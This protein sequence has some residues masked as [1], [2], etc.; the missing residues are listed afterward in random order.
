MRIIGVTSAEETRKHAGVLKSIITAQEIQPLPFRQTDTFIHRV[1]Y[2][3]VRFTDP[4]GDST[5]IFIDD[6][7]GRIFRTAVDND[8]FQVAEALILYASDRLL[9]RGCS[10]EDNGDDGDQW[11]FHR[12][13]FF[14]DEGENILR[15]SRKSRKLLGKLTAMVYF[16]FHFR[17]NGSRK[18]R[19]L[20]SSKVL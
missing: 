6:V 12:P 16:L 10:I 5:R 11:L 20:N 1:I 7:D 4:S 9:Q 3:F 19:C 15:K 14:D 18:K 8:K 17:R 13:V 2:P